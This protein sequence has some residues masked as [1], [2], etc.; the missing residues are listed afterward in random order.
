MCSKNISCLSPSL[1]NSDLQKAIENGELSVDELTAFGMSNWNDGTLVDVIL[2]LIANRRQATLV[3]LTEARAEQFGKLTDHEYIARCFC[4]QGHATVELLK[5]YSAATGVV[6]RNEHVLYVIQRK[7][8]RELQYMYEESEK[9][10]LAEQENAIPTTPPQPI[11]SVIDNVEYKT[12]IKPLPKRGD[13]TLE[14]SSVRTAFSN[15]WLEGVEWIL[16][17]GNLD[18]N[19][20]LGAY[21]F[22]NAVSRKWL[23]GIKW[24]MTILKIEPSKI[25]TVLAIKLMFNT[26]WREGLEYITTD[27]KLDLFEIDLVAFILD[28]PDS[29]KFDTQCEMVRRII[30]TGKGRVTKQQM[31]RIKSNHFRTLITSLFPDNYEPVDVVDIPVEP[32][33]DQCAVC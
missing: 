9:R 13:I 3:T 10:R 7:Q 11:V 28:A 21:D 5:F 15:A 18:V 31:T 24:L 29:D 14:P 26:A 23:E 20:C 32:V 8:L 33:K 17:T 25:V 16:E 30:E 4:R 6:Y 2:N 22:E 19:T 12:E 1:N 27:L